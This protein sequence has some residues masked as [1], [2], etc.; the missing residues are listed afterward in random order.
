[1]QPEDGRSKL[2]KGVSRA[3]I[4][5]KKNLGWLPGFPFAAEPGSI[6]WWSLPPEAKAGE[7][8]T[9]DRPQLRH[10]EMTL[11]K[12]RHRFPNA[13]PKLV[14]DVDDWFGRM[15]FLLAMLK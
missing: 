15:D 10:M 11:T 9:L 14:E 13:L 5:L 1:M 6:R 2:Q 8:V 12:L 4:L 7:V 3:R